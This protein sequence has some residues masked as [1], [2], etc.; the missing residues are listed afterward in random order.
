MLVSVIVAVYKCEQYIRQCVDSLI[1][2]SYSDLEILICDDCSP[3]GT[4]NILK[5]YT[6]VRVKIYRNEVN[7]GV[8]SVRNFLLQKV[9]GEFVLIQDGDDWSDSRRVEQLLEVFRSDNTLSACGTASYRIDNKGMITNL[10]KEKSFDITLED[11]KNLP[12]MPA[13][14]MLRYKVYEELGGYNPYFNGLYSEDL[15]WILRIV[16]K[17]KVFYLNK[18]LYYYRFNSSSITNSVGSRNKLIVDELMHVLI[19]Q[20]KQFGEDWVERNNHIAIDKFV[21]TK[22]RD[23]KWLSEKYRVV[24]AV[25]RDGNKRRIAFTYILKSLACNPFAIK[26]YITL[27]YILFSR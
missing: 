10:A 23:R 25:Q 18:P 3:D 13:T 5:S 20:R 14:L 16:E 1:N 2:Q 4:W 19:D 24:A 27:K 7:Q 9:T 26:N 21:V 17:F 15:Y 6:D 12:F 11:C 22:F 8:V